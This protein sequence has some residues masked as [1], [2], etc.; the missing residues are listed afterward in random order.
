MSRRS[1]ILKGAVAGAAGG[2][3]ASFVMN[4]FQGVWSAAEKQLG[5]A[6]SA[7]QGEPANETAA[8]KASKAATGR[9]LPPKAREPA[10]QVVHYATGVGL[11]VAYGVLAELWPRITTGF[12]AAYGSAVNLILDESLV[13]ALGLGPSPF[14]TPLKIHAYGAASHSVFGVALELGRKAVRTIL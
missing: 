1:D 4:R 9:K 11:G 3:L 13:P 5:M 7:G 6:D 8:D 2:L 12:G 14:K 10:G